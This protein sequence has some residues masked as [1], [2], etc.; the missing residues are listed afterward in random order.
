MD[1]PAYGLYPPVLIALVIFSYFNA[2]RKAICFAGDVGSISVGFIIFYGMV[3]SIT[4]YHTYLPLLLLA[5]YGVDSGLTIVYRLQQRQNIFQAHQLH[6]YQWLVR[7]RGWSHL[8]VA[9]LYALIQTGINGLVIWS[10]DRP[11]PYH[12]MLAGFVLGGLVVGYISERWVLTDSTKKAGF[13][14]T[15]LQV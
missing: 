4:H 15:G 6:L 12:F 7:E 11:A 13:E 3:T 9:T 14:K 8:R 5:V 1:S 2:R 10:I